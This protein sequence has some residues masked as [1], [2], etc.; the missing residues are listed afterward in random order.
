V[1]SLRLDEVSRGKMR[2]PDLVLVMNRV[3]VY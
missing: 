1:S 3:T 2:I